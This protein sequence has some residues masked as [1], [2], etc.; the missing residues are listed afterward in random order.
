MACS[1][2]GEEEE[3]EE[4][5]WAPNTKKWKDQK[6]VVQGKQNVGQVRNV[7]LTDRQRIANT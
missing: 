7:T 3:E 6:S 2:R 5:D 4:A 1:K